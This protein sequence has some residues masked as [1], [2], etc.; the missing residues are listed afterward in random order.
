VAGTAGV[1][2]GETGGLA[3]PTPIRDARSGEL[4]RA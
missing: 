2:E 1:L 4:L 3:Q